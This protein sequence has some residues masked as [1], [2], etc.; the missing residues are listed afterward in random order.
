MRA[1]RPEGSHNEASCFIGVALALVP[2]LC[3][4]V[5]V[6]RKAWLAVC[7]VI[8]SQAATVASLFYNA[9]SWSGGTGYF[10]FMYRVVY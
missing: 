8:L 3:L 6:R 10:P 4:K 1:P 7:G 2:L 5:L 9:S